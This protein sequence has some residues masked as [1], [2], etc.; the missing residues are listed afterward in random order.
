MTQALKEASE[1]S[2]DKLMVAFAPTTFLL[3]TSPGIVVR[4]KDCMGKSG[5]SGSLD[6]VCAGYRARSC[7]SLRQESYVS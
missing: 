1:M 7:Q 2:G 6:V 4:R 3:S 5:M